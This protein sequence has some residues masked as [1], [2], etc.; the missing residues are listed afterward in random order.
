MPNS[1]TNVV[2]ITGN[3]EV[4]AEISEQ[5]GGCRSFGYQTQADLCRVLGEAPDG[6]A[7]SFLESLLPLPD[8]AGRGEKIRRWGV[9]W[10]DHQCSYVTT[11]QTIVAVFVTPWSSPVH[12]VGA[13]AKRWSGATISVDWYDEGGEHGAYSFIDGMPDWIARILRRTR[14]SEDDA[15]VISTSNEDAA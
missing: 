8:D 14:N 6:R 10:A 15:V 3:D 5:L 13:I 12:G 4:L 9:K 11:G 2:R 1:I 7:N